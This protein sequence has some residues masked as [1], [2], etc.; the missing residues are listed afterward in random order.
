MT[1]IFS[2]EEE[3]D[4]F[5]INSANIEKSGFVPE[6]GVKVVKQKVDKK[7]DATGIL[8]IF[9]FDI[10]TSQKEEKRDLE[11]FEENMETS[12][13]QEKTKKPIPKEVCGSEDIKK[14]KIMMDDDLYG[15]CYPVIGG[16]VFADVDKNG[17]I[18]GQHIRTDFEDKQEEKKKRSRRRR[19]KERNL[20]KEYDD[21]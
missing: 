20:F 13:V 5:G 21:E 16:S 1:N 11:E 18:T 17:K 14:N 3:E 4:V 2:S 7:K 6:S 8:D 10:A 9:G 12:Q 15:E 19:N